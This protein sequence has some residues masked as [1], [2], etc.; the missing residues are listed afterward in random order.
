MRRRALTLLLASLALPTLAPATAL[1]QGP[2]PVQ[3]NFVNAQL[4]DVVRSMAVILGVNVVLTEVPDLRITFSTPRPVLVGQVGGVLE[5]I[6][7]SNGLVLV[8]NGAVAQ[9]MP[10]DRAPATGPV[11]SG[12]DLPDPPPLGLITQ[13]VPLQGIRAQEGL[14]VLKPFASAIAHI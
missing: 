4:S 6:L 2:Q 3:L 10:A 7:E 5:S 13:I 9:V 11:G 14:D 8:Q 12:L 1:A